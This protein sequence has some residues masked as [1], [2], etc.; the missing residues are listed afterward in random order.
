MFAD[1]MHEETEE[2]VTYRKKYGEDFPE[3]IEQNGKTYKRYF[4]S[5]PVVDV[6]EGFLGNAKDGY[7]G[8]NAT[9]V[10]GKFTPLNKVYGRFGRMAG[11][12]SDHKY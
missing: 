1:Y 6:C 2:I 5:M 7:T 3:Q 12:E 11:V 10:P 8:G 9:Y 4:G